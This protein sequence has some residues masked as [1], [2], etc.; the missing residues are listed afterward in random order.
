M[1][2]V[3]G[4]GRKAET[5]LY[6]QGDSAGQ[7]PVSY[8]VTHGR[9]ANSPHYPMDTVWYGR[10]A[11]VD[12]FWCHSSYI[13]TKPS[14]A[15]S[16]S[17]QVDQFERATLQYGIDC[18]RCHGPAAEHVRYQQEHPDEKEAKFVRSW[19]GLTREQRLDACAVCHSGIHS[20][21]KS[22]FGFRPGDK[23]SNFYYSEK[24]DAPPDVHGNQY[25]ALVSSRCFRESATLECSSCHDVHVK[26][27]DRLDLFSQRCMN[28]H[29]SSSIGSIHRG[30]DT[31]ALRSNCIDCHMPAQPSRLITM[32][33][34]PGKKPVADMIRN[35][36]IGVY[37]KN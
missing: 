21:L 2:V 10:M 26:E 31:V 29:V 19:R 25:A 24:T 9:W 17:F 14:I 36:L 33:L 3:I 30:M 16:A 22:A 12:C 4:S 6:W 8:F 1:D 28:C 23:L 11:T 5:F 34:E 13:R 37:K 7:L 35:H 15:V 20:P 18:E 32:Q 27:R